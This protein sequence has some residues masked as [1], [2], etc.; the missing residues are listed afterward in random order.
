MVYTIPTF[1]LGAAFGGGL[2]QGI[3][4][5]LGQL[6][7]QQVELG[8]AGRLQQALAGLSPEQL[9]DPVQLYSALA[10]RPEIAQIGRAHV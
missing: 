10:E 3:G 5:A 8:Q 1:D 2:G 7:Q 6:G 4:S 9:Q